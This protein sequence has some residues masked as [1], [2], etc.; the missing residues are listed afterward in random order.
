[1]NGGLVMIEG[2]GERDF[3]EILVGDNAIELDHYV[4]GRFGLELP[5]YLAEL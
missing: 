1:V 2:Y 3:G 5:E 4:L